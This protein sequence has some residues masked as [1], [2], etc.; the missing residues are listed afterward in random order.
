MDIMDITIA[1]PNDN[2]PLQYVSK[3]QVERWQ[4]IEAAA[5]VLVVSLIPLHTLLVN[6]PEAG[7]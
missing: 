6:D 2:T 4:A 3:A 1:S 5:K 7:R